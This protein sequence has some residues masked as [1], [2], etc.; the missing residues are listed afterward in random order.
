MGNTVE[1]QTP[2]QGEWRFGHPEMAWRDGR[3]LLSPP[4]VE[5]LLNR[6][7]FGQLVVDAI[8]KTNDPERHGRFQPQIEYGFLGFRNYIDIDNTHYYLTELYMGEEEKEGIS[9]SGLEDFRR[10]LPGTDFNVLGFRLHAHPLAAIGTRRIFRAIFGT[11]IGEEKSESSCFSRPDLKNFYHLACEENSALING[12]GIPT[13]DPG[14]GEILLVSFR[15]LEAFKHF[16]PTLREYVST[17]DLPTARE[18]YYDIYRQAGLNVA[19][20]GVNLTGLPVLDPKEVRLAAA[21]LTAS[22]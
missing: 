19:L 8:Q 5:T 20:L 16:D 9:F 13:L 1:G 22:E 11:D 10:S 21:T 4:I 6:T 17:R 14:R 18:D 3:A 2:E 15:T 7:D 12:L